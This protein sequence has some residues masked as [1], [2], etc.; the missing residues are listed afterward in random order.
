M[1]EKR[2]CFE[3][4]SG[5]S[6]VLGLYCRLR[7]RAAAEQA[8]VRFSYYRTLSLCG[9]ELACNLFERYYSVCYSCGG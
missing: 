8:P 7:N 3:K 6:K 5:L 2:Q 9:M 4:G 1:S